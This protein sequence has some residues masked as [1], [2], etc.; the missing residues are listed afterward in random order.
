MNPGLRGTAGVAVALGLV[1]LVVAAGATRAL[2]LRAVTAAQSV[3]SPTLDVVASLVPV[4]GRADLTAVIALVMALVWWRREG[5]RGLVPLLFFAG[6]PLE[7]AM[8]QVV[9]HPGPPRALWRTLDLVPSFGL[10]GLGMSLVPYAFPSG[11]LLRTTFLVA[12]VGARAPRW[13]TIPL[14][15]LVL[16]IAATHVYL[17]T[18]WVSDVVGGLLAGWLLARLAIALGGQGAPTRHAS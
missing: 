1:S 11:H 7:I 6:V 12:L 5:A 4:L 3:A 9:P 15:S 18:H 13:A 2:D 8:K 17:A 16:A 10:A 14:A